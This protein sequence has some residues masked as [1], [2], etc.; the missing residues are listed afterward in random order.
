MTRLDWFEDSTQWFWNA[1]I[2]L[3][4]WTWFYSD[5]NN[6]ENC[7]IK[8]CENSVKKKNLWIE[9]VISGSHNL[10]I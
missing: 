9:K 3:E 4:W 10:V 8:E 2:S 6:I 1:H 7:S 5:E